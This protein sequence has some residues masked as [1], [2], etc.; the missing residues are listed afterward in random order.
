[1]SELLRSLLIAVIAYLLGCFST[2]ITISRAQGIDIR[3]K[4]SKNTGASNVLRVMGLKSGLLTFVGDFLKA[5]LACWIGSL[6]LPGETFGVAGFGTMLGGLFAVLGHNW[7]VFYGFKGGKGVACS[8]AVVFF[9][10]PLWGI[11][12]I[13]LCLGVIAATRY[14]SLGSMTLLFLYMIFMCIAFWG[15]W[16]VCLFTVVLFALCVWRHRANI[17]RLLS[18]TENKIG[19]KAKD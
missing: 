8:A 3:S 19:H 1:M 14:I 10:N 12:A 6:I 9:V 4:G 11:I 15:Q 5:T 13:V 16:V 2:G 17:Q 18:G 7:P